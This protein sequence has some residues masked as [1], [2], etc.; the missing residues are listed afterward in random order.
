MD[1]RERLV[2]VCA[3]FRT[4]IPIL[5]KMLIWQCVLVSIWSS[6]IC[7]HAQLEMDRLGSV[8]AEN[9][10]KEPSGKYRASCYLSATTK[11][12]LLSRGSHYEK[13]KAST[14]REKERSQSDLNNQRLYPKSERLETPLASQK[15][16]TQRNAWEVSLSTHSQLSL[17]RRSK[18]NHSI[19]SRWRGSLLHGG[20]L[21]G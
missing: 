14:I 17:I 16:L 2:D 8:W 4:S 19:T 7:Y 15:W 12:R 3:S 13:H 10:Y 9:I 5:A 1:K 20:D 6:S 21:K 11:R 18:G